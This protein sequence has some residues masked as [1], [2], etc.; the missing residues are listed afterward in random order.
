M[1]NGLWKVADMRVYGQIVVYASPITY[2][3]QMVNGFIFANVDEADL[4][5]L[6]ATTFSSYRCD[7]SVPGLSQDMLGTYVASQL[8]EEP[9]LSYSQVISRIGG[10]CLRS[11]IGSLLD[12][13]ACLAIVF[14]FLASV[15]GMTVLVLRRRS[16]TLS[17]APS[18]DH[19]KCERFRSSS[20]AS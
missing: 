3:I 8:L 2:T 11:L 10:T 6:C 9:S 16:A 20:S 19:R 5:N 13:D 7:D 4:A 12:P 17:M 18:S 1:G 15:V 14:A